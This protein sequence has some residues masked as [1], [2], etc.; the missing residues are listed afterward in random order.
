MCELWGNDRAFRLG[1]TVREVSG[2]SS[3]V[4]NNL[5]VVGEHAREECR[6]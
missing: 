6:K 1:L 2:W 5:H 3:L 4:Y